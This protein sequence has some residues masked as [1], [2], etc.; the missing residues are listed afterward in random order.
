MSTRERRRAGQTTLEV[1]RL[2]LALLARM[3]R[4]RWVTAS[5]LQA[6]LKSAGIERGI[7]TVQRLLD[8]L[9]SEYDIERAE[10]SKP[11]RYRWSS[12]ARGLSIPTLLPQEALVLALAHRHLMRLL[13]TGVTN[14]LASLFDQAERQIAGARQPGAEAQWLQKVQVADALQ[15]LIA[16]EICETVFENISL[17]LFSNRWLDISYRNAGGRESAARVMP[18]GLVQQRERMYLVC[19]YESFDDERSLALHRIVS[20]RASAL[21]F[22]PPQEFS[23]AQ[24]VSEGRNAFGGGHRIHLCFRIQRENGAHLLESRLSQDQEVIVEGDTYVIRATVFDSAAL[25]WWLQTFGGAITD[26]RKVPVDVAL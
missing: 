18:L 4:S 16:P 25:D 11:Y 24:H 23:L 3:P 10:D 22:K 19:R 21:D 1:L 9:S 15:P 20:A 26:I 5:E 7:R 17:A 6:Q 12:S 8:V 2:A 14:S 13:P